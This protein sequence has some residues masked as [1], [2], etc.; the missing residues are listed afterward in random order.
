MQL[1]MTVLILMNKK[2][3]P[4]KQYLCAYMFVHENVCLVCVDVCICMLL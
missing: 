2:P 4:N 1:L 3:L